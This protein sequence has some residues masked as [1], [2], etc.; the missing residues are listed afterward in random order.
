[1]S[2]LYCLVGL[3][4]S[5]KSTAA[6]EM[7]KAGI[8]WH[9]SDAIRQELFGDSTDQS[10]NEA[11][12][13]ALNKRVKADLLDGHDVAYDATN[14][15]AKRR[16]ALL[17]HL[18]KAATRKV[19]VVMATPYE[20]VLINN[21][22]REHP[23]PKVAIQKMYRSFWVPQYFEG[24]DEIHFEYQANVP[25]EITKLYS[26]EES[27]FQQLEAFEQD[28]IH[29]G[30]S[31]GA[32]MRETLANVIKVTGISQERLNLITAA[33]MH[34]VGKA[35]TKAF[36]NRDGEAVESA[37]YYGHDNVSA[38]DMMCFAYYGMRETNVNNVLEMIFYVQY[39]MRPFFMKEL[40]TR[41]KFKQKVGNAWYEDI[42][43]LH[44]ADKLAKQKEGS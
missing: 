25:E 35:K 19:A 2:I 16:G 11:V 6:K 32:H 12:F 29:H 10:N 28:N 1:M 43:I 33:G 36:F 13:L 21:Q 27:F 23:V 5:G 20:Q 9:S 42:Y 31:L 3:P 7:Q 30:L 26:M 39:H 34:D 15:S 18:A 37:T 14:I 17:N 38:Y 22:N 40:S 41:N 4:G 8:I 44:E 24:W